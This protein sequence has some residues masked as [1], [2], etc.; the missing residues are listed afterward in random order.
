MHKH[1]TITVDGEDLVLVG[2][3]QTTGHVLEVA[4]LHPDRYDL[5]RVLPDGS[6][7]TLTGNVTLTDGDEFVTARISTTTA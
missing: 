3:Q 1:V 6:S 2:G 7:V 4:G 5:Q